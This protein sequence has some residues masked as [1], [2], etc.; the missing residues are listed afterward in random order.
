VKPSINSIK[1]HPQLSNNK[2]LVD[3]VLVGVG[4]LGPWFWATQL[5]NAL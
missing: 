5:R 1:V 2:H 4:T 3:G